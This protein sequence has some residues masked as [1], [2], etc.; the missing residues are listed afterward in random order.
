MKAPSPRPAADHELVV[1]APLA[2]I[3]V[4]DH[5][6]QGTVPL[7]LTTLPKIRV[8]QANLSAVLTAFRRIANATKPMTATAADYDHFGAA[9]DV[10][11]T[12]IEISDQLRTLHLSLL[13]A[14]RQAAALPI[15]L[16]YHG[17]GYRPHV[18]HAHNGDRVCPGDSMDLTALAVLDC[19]RPLRSITAFWPLGDQPPV[20]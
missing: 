15:Q 9:A 17:D 4:G 3:S 8:P 6:E 16:A 13:E 11:V 1:I 5:F 14:A 18:T 12:T 19:S 10:G 2:P 20:T 7:H